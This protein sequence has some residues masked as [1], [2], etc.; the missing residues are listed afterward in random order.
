MMFE[1]KNADIS[2]IKQIFNL[3]YETQ[4]YVDVSVWTPL[5]LLRAVAFN[6]GSVSTVQGFRQKLHKFSFYF[7]N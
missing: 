6:Q 5:K 3:Y 4:F 7:I 2:I 1:R